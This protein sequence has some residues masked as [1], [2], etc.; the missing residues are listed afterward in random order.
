LL[1]LFNASL[2]VMLTGVIAGLILGLVT[3][4]RM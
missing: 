2:G 1:A 4:R 3:P